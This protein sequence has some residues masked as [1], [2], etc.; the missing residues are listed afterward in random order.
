VEDE[1]E[2]DEGKKGIVAKSAMIPVTGACNMQDFIVINR[3]GELI[4]VDLAGNETSL[5]SNFDPKINEPDTNANICKAVVE[6]IYGLYLIGT[7]GSTYQLTDT[8][9]DHN[10]QFF[11]DTLIYFN[12]DGVMMYTDV[13]G[14]SVT[15]VGSGIRT[16][17]GANGMMALTDANG[18]L[19]VENK[20]IANN[21]IGI[22]WLPDGSGIIF[23]DTCQRV[24]D[25]ASAS[26]STC[27]GGNDSAPDPHKAGY[28]GFVEL[29]YNVGPTYANQGEYPKFKDA[30]QPDWS[31][32]TPIDFDAT[33]VT[34]W[35][36]GEPEILVCPTF[37]PD[38]NGTSIVD[39]LK[40]AS[41]P[42]DIESRE[43]LMEAC[44]VDNNFDLLLAL[45]SKS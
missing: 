6:T 38:Y 19:L 20:L 18:N 12:R 39:F 30:I 9:A 21:A 34:I 27:L 37:A 1:E 31:T 8:G 13:Q 25:F 45:N 10:P 5:T 28:V 44:G 7:D 26:A 33:A 40:A 4:M 41:Q 17:F 35:L 16:L 15:K 43:T 32:T 23:Y 42:S 2:K 24:Y 11:D 22:N 29:G 36:G 3:L 14:T